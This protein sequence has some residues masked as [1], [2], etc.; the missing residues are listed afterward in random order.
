MHSVKNFHWTHYGF[1][2]S[3]ESVSPRKL[4]LHSNNAVFTRVPYNFDKVRWKPRPHIKTAYFV[5]NDA[6][7]QKLSMDTQIAI[8]TSP[9]KTFCQKPKSFTPKIR[10]FLGN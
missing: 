9:Q 1:E 7:V 5:K 8:F 4:S 6:F 2:F 3:R 10:N